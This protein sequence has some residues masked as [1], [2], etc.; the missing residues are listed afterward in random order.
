MCMNDGVVAL[1]CIRTFPGI[2][3]TSTG[4][5]NVMVILPAFRS[6]EK[7]WSCG[8]TGS[9]VLLLY[10]RGDVCGRTMLLL[11]SLTSPDVNVRPMVPE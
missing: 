5:E 11:R 8:C 6:R 4:S 2:S 10:V 3:F 7:D 9:E 1:F